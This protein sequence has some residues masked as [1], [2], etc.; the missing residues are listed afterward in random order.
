MNSFHFL[1]NFRPNF[2]NFWRQNFF[3][4]WSKESRPTHKLPLSPES[5]DTC[6]P[7]L[8]GDEEFGRKILVEK[9]FWT[10]ILLTLCAAKCPNLVLK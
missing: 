9:W 5:D 7:K 6:S 8:N 10:T 3:G 4:F 1:D 2:V